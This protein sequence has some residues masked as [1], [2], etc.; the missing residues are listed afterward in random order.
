MTKSST[1]EQSRG[2][3]ILRMSCGPNK[4][5]A[6]RIRTAVAAWIRARSSGRSKCNITESRGAAV[7]QTQSRAMAYLPRDYAD[8]RQESTTCCDV[9]AISATGS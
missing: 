5:S 3:E 9:T 1:A 2:L 8:R 7:D 4:P 6:K